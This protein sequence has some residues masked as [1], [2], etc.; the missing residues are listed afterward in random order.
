MKDPNLQAII[1][2]LTDEGLRELIR[3]AQNK[4]E[5]NYYERDGAKDS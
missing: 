4:L 5:K 2:D 3:L 1:N